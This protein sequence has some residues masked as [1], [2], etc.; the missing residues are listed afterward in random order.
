LNKIN[1]G[2]YFAKRLAELVGAEKIL[3][4]KSGYFGRSAAAN[5]FDKELIGKCAELA[6]ESAIVDVS[7]CMGQ[8]E[9][10]E[11]TPIRAIE[12]EHIKGHKPF[13]TNTAWFQQMVK[14]IGQTTA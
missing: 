6:V 14:D 4:Q 7:G 8:D 12:F 1:P 11:G 9:D 2:Q 3:V 5:D 10:K 13:D